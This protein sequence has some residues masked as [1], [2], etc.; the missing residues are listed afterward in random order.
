[1]F[2]K[3]LNSLLRCLLPVSALLLLFS[4]WIR[5]CPPL[6][7]ILAGDG[8]RPGMEWVEPAPPGSL[9]AVPDSRCEADPPFLVLLV[10]S[11][12]EGASE[13]AAIRA[14]WGAER[15]VAGRRVCAFFL[16][17]YAAGS[18]RR[19][20]R[21]IRSHRDI[22]QGNF[23]D[24]YHNLTRKVLMG[25][26]WVHRLC[27]GARFV[28]KT[29]SD[30]FVNTF[31]LTHLLEG[32]ADTGFFSGQLMHDIRPIKDKSSKWY[33]SEEE[34][35]LPEYPHYCSGTGYVLSADLAGK[36]WDISSSVPLLRLEDAYM[37]LC[38][39]K[40]EVSPVTMSSRRVFFTRKVPFTVCRYRTLVTSHRVSPAELRS[41]WRALEEARNSQCP[42]HASGE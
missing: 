9:L 10:T 6:P 24:A 15:R 36:I 31:Y 14:T 12:P 3:R 8:P 1:M 35:A 28:M 19:I 32:K 5:H 30:M 34:F 42:L 7:R 2:P 11:R 18:Q 25:L 23:T 39:S 41:Y 37:G 40:L 27:S 13:R 29:D 20:R 26:G 17:G 33:V 4:R 22:I 16:L 21:E 38:L